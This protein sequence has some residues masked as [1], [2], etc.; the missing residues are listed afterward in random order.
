METQRSGLN[1]N[2]QQVFLISEAA[3]YARVSQSLLRAAIRRG[4]LQAV[5]VGRGAQRLHVRITRPALLRWLGIEDSHGESLPT[6]TEAGRR[7]VVARPA[8]G[9]EAQR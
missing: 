7:P 9:G 4:E 3:S 1:S 5:R 6:E 2:L 8:S